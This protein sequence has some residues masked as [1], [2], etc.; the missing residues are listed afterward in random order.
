MWYFSF[1]LETNGQAQSGAL[2]AYDDDEAWKAQV[3]SSMNSISN[4]ASPAIVEK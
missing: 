1:G 3:A 4:I 2:L